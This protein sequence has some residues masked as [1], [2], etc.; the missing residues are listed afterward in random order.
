MLSRLRIRRSPGRHWKLMTAT[1]GSFA[2]AAISL[3]AAEYL[4]SGIAL[5]LGATTLAVQWLCIDP[6]YVDDADLH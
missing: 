1:L 6:P 5:L 2:L 4:L 3:V